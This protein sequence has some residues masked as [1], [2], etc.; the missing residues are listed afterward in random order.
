MDIV[1]NG[2]IECA[3]GLQVNK[4]SLEG[5]ASSNG[6]KEQSKSNDI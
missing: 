5:L 3:A 6:E 2:D 4:Y 1:V